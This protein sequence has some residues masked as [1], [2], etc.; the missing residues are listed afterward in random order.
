M[1][2]AEYKAIKAHILNYMTAEELAENIEQYKT[3]RE[4]NGTTWGAVQTMAQYGCF[5]VYYSQVLDALKEIYGDEFK[6][7]TYLTKS[8]ELRYKGGECYA[9]TIYKAKLAKACEMMEKKGEL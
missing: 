7:S 6:E 9:W 2:I 5:A 3:N 4:S 1:K 8:G